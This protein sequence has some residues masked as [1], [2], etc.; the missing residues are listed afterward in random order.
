MSVIESLFVGSIHPLAPSSWMDT[1]RMDPFIGSKVSLGNLFLLQI[2]IPVV[3]NRCQELY[4]TL[5][6]HDSWKNGSD[7]IRLPPELY[8]SLP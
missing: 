2:Q 6:E 8:S 7:E 5:R 3:R 4:C 1:R